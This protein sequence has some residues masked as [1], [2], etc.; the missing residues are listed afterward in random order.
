MSRD[1]AARTLRRFE[2]EIG[3]IRESGEPMSARV[4]VLALGAFVALSILLL[5]V[6]RVDRVV[7]SSAGKIVSVQPPS[8]FQALDTSIVKSINVREGEV[9]E[10]GQVLATLDPTFAAADVNQLRQQLKSL[11]AQLARDEAE[12]AHAALRF[13][14]GADAEAGGYQQLQLGL[15]R[16]RR[17]QYDA[18]LASFDEKIAQTQSTIDKFK[19]DEGRYRER[20]KIADQVQD[21]RSTLLQ[22]GNGTLLNLLVS[23]DARLEALRTME[24]GHNSLLEAEHMMAALQADRRAFEEQW[25]SQVSQDL[26][27]ARNALDGARNQLEKA[28][29]HK[30]LV[31]LVAPQRAMVLSLA[32]QSV[33][34]V[35]REGDT[36]LVLAP[37]SAP[38]EAEVQLES[39][40]IGFVRPGDP[41]TLKVDAFNF[42]EHG[43]AEGHVKWISEDAFTTDEN[44]AAVTPYYRARIAVDAIR[45][46]DVPGNFRL[47][48]GM[49]LSADIKVGS[50]ALGL[51]LLGGL[52]HGAG[53][54]MREP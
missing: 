53:E 54:A 16:Q 18:Q 52:V 38:L 10:A 19:G 34:S 4:T 14:P 43:V 27:T 1:L 48:P 8:V 30:D 45:F 20:L 31:R 11:D 23:S 39:R 41:V 29:K 36:L 17:D 22:H 50:R 6:A 3:D 46:V 32:K 47:I 7:S 44:G 15:F 33:G 12:L 42:A 49:R 35:L 2:S 21:M 5:A 37:M 9:V 25:R 26:V 51:Y 13:E 28:E 40:D 24:F